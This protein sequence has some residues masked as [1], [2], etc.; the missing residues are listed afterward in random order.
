M[1]FRRIVLHGPRVLSRIGRP[2]LAT[3]TA[4]PDESDVYVFL[5]PR[6]QFDGRAVRLHPDGDLLQTE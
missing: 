4:G 1:A 6:E 3:D 2:E 5:K